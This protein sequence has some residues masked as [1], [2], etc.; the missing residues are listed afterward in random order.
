VFDVAKRRHVAT[1][2]FSIPAVLAVLNGVSV[3]LAYIVSQ[4]NTTATIAW[5]AITAGVSAAL[6]YYKEHD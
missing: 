1:A 5:L 6:S 3:G 4:G 2:F